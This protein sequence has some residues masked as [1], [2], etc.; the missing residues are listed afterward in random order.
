[1]SDLLKLSTFAKK[2]YFG[3]NI[4]LSSDGNVLAIG[5]PG[6]NSF[7]GAV[8]IYHKV[9]GEW[10]QKDKL[11]TE[12]E[13]SRF[14]I[15]IALSSD[16][17]ILAVGA[18]GENAVYIYRNICGNWI[19]T[20]R[21]CG[22]DGSYYGDCIALSADGKTLVVGAYLENHAAGAVYVYQNS[23]GVWEKTTLQVGNG[24]SK[25]FGISVAVSADGL[26][27]IVGASLENAAYIY[28]NIRGFWNQKA[29]LLGDMPLPGDTNN[30]H[31]GNSVALSHNGE[32][33][34]IGSFGEDDY[35]GSVYLFEDPK[36]KCNRVAKLAYGSFNGSYGTSV[37]L[38][39]DGLTL[40]VGASLENSNIGAAY[41]YCNSA[42]VWKQT[43][44]TRGS[45]P[46]GRFG[47]SVALNSSGS[48]AAVAAPYEGEDTGAVY[49]LS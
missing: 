38:S 47:N 22:E 42:G 12:V 2:S 3:M 33:V 29:R 25:W 24:K 20:D 31:F 39:A 4:A 44:K 6:K 7:T 21:L 41:T 13:D 15:S 23:A 19:Q 8:Y 32:V 43:S 46:N 40:I 35:T 37:S 16:G 48:I 9:G 5:A 1:M 27:L 10:T 28:Q 34:A 49:L 26:T 36:F 18:C 45:V 11:F 30:G 14:G 17:S